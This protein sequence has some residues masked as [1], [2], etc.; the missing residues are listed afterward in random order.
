MGGVYAKTQKGIYGIKLLLLLLP[1]VVQI[2]NEKYSNFQKY[3]LNSSLKKIP[4]N[5]LIFG[6]LRQV[7][8]LSLSKHVDRFFNGAFFNY[9]SVN[10]KFKEQ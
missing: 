3:P 10:N 8:P 7:L 6:R 1:D 2:T 4:E 5:H 9:F